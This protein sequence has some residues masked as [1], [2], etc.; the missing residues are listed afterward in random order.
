MQK[1]IRNK[2]SGRELKMMSLFSFLFYVILAY[3]IFYFFRSQ[4]LTD[5]FK[6]GFSLQHQLL[7]G[8]ISGFAAS[9]LIIFFSSRSPVKQ[10]LSD[11]SVYKII[12]DLEISLFDR[13]HISV[14][15]GFG[16]E[17][18]FRGAIQPLLG[19]WLTSFIFTAIHGY[20]SFRSSG[21]ILFTLLLFGLSMMLGV[22]YETAGLVSAIIAHTVYDLIMLEWVKRARWT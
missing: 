13:I 4:D 21:H 8:L 11:F 10:V 17:L 22:L 7:T 16:E 14:F 3:V 9:G 5:A 15:A 20:I 1:T 12:S 19:I 2:P 6:H 18:L